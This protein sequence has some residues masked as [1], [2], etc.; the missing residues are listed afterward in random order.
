MDLQAPMN[1]CYIRP[2]VLGTFNSGHNFSSIYCSRQCQ[3]YKPA[4]IYTVYNIGTRFVEHFTEGRGGD[5]RMQCLKDDEI[6]TKLFVEPPGGTRC[7]I[8][9]NTL[10]PLYRISFML[11]MFKMYQ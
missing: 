4:A 9:Y 8:M 11:V 1:D 5:S 10:I 7:R 3:G 2:D 6:D